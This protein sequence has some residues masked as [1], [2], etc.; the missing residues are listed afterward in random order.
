VADTR[1]AAAV[2]RELFGFEQRSP[3]DPQTDVGTNNRST[4]FIQ[5]LIVLMLNRHG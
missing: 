4:F 1:K 2:Y 3:D 5:R